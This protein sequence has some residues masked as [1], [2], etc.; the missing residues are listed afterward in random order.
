MRPKPILRQRGSLVVRRFAAF[1]FLAPLFSLGLVAPTSSVDAVAQVVDVSDPQLTDNQAPALLAEMRR[2][3]H[4]EPAA[5]RLAEAAQLPSPGS[6]FAGLA[7]QGEGIVLYYKGDLPEHMQ[8]ALRDA[9]K[10]GPVMVVP[11]TYS[12][13]ELERAQAALTTAVEQSHVEVEA[14]GVAEDGSGLVVDVMPAVK[15]KLMRETL[16]AR[17]GITTLSAHDFLASARL[18]V[19]VTVRT[20]AGGLTFMPSRENDYAPWNGGDEYETWRGLDERSSWCSTAFGVTKGS[21]TYVLTAAHCMTAPDVAYNG[22]FGGC[23]FEEIGPVYSENWDKDILLINARGSV[24]MFDGGVDSSIAKTVH[25]WGYR[26]KDELLCTSGS[27]S[28]VICGD[29]TDPYEYNVY[30]CDSDG[31]C[32]TM[33]DMAKAKNINNQCVGVG[34]DSGGPVFSLDG[35]GVRAKGVIS[36]KA[37]NDCT[38]LYFQDMDEIVGS[39][40]WYPRTA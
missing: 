20:G 32:F 2:Q 16:A 33:H 17:K 13:Q 34:G 28:G 4:L 22:H 23:C 6:G 5:Q 19:S 11:A 8:A 36:G 27:R 1:S 21:Q 38:I 14:I 35:N 26:V 3:E 9:R 30:G 15:A 37:S 40:G 24:L 31:D 29:K 25:S 12:R 18:D 10:I 7:Y 39:M